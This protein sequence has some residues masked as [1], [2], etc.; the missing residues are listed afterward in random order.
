[1]MAEEDRI[2]NLPDDIIH[3]ILSFLDLKYAMQTSALSKKW[4]LV[5]TL[6]P[7]L[8][9]NSYNFSNPSHF[10][11]FVKHALLHRNNLREVSVLEL[12][13][14]GVV[15]QFS[16]KSIVNYACLHNV[17]RLTIVWAATGLHEFPEFL[18]SCR[19][20]EDLTLKVQ[21]RTS[22]LARCYISELGWDFPA[23]E[24]LNLRNFKLDG[25]KNKCINLFSKCVNLKDLTLHE[26]DTCGL[27][28][29][30]L[31]V[32]Q[33]SNLSITFCYRYSY[34]KV[35]NPKVLNVVGHQLQNLT[36]SVDSIHVLHLTAEG[37]DSIKKVNL[38]WPE[39]NYV[40]EKTRFSQ[41]VGVFQKLCS[42]KVLILDPYIIKVLSS[43]VDQLLV[44][45]GPFNNLKCLK[46][47]TMLETR[48]V[49]GATKWEN[50][51]V[52]VQLK[53]YFLD[54][55]PT[56]TFIIGYPQVPRKRP[57]QQVHDDNDALAKKKARLDLEKQ[58]LAH[59]TIITQ[60]KEIFDAYI[61]MQ[62]EVISEQEAML[63]A[64][65]Q[66]QDE[67]ISKQ[68]AMFE[69]HIHMLD[70]LIIKQKAMFE[71]HINMLDQAILKQK[72]LFEGNI[73]MEGQVINEANAMLEA[74]IQMLDEGIRK[75]KTVFEA[76]IQMVDQVIMKQKEIVVT[77]HKAM[78]DDERQMQDQVITK[79]EMIFDAETQMLFQVI[80]SQ[81]AML[82]A[83]IQMQHNVIVEQ[84]T[85]IQMLHN[86]IVEQKARIRNT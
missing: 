8:N 69:A 30:N 4:K 31:C 28:E 85:K 2:S 61:H 22:C 25:G 40:P 66:M 19:A 72:A 20:L 79:Q 14:R 53:N 46:M 76:Y 84:K 78:F 29:L 68:K 12:R 54:K 81:K 6:L 80:T 64:K 44:E 23:L 33:L 77:G 75:L 38:S 59:T 82:D 42:A 36:A 27:E 26:I 49:C 58:Q 1:M 3:H 70:Q 21:D 57:S 43:C 15:T 52:P 63:K 41:L 47:N 45:P 5:W 67:A 60:D 11:E 37:F 35:P 65:I 74:K 86:A 71:A 55:S 18:F 56:A 73:Q 50:V 10:N 32:L 17:K 62:D 9:F 24:K 34:P 39:I 16:G 83:I 48:Y 7:Q 51:V 13:C